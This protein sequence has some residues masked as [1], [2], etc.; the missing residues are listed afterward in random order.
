[1]FFDSLKDEM[2]FYVGETRYRFDKESGIAGHVAKTGDILNVPDA[3]S[4]E[5]FNSNLDK[6]T[7]F[8]TKS[9]LCAPIRSRS[10]DGV[11]AVI[12][13]LN[14]VDKGGVFTTF[15]EE[16]SGSEEQIEEL[17]RRH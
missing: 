3:Y 6:Q 12:Q 2:F 17:R 8:K 13:M 5:S 15:D 14:K 10:G 7:G 1:M 9:I 4:H 11:V 16:V